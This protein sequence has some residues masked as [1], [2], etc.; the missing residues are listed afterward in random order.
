M[1]LNFN[2]TFGLGDIFTL[3][4]GLSIAG[5]F[6]YRRGSGDSKLE[7]AVT[8]AVAEITELKQDVKKMGEVLVQLAVQKTELNAMKDQISMVLKWYD[9][10][11]RGTGWVQ[12]HK[13][14]DRQYPP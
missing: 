8:Q 2:W 4:S 12:G 5:A 11:R 13:G 9:E 7:N 1:G 14:V 3:L 10:L 6:L